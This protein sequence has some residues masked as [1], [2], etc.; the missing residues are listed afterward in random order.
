MPYASNRELP[1]QVKDNL[2]GHG[3]DI[4]REAFNHAF[5]N[6]KDPAKRRGHASREE[7][8]HKIAWSAVKHEYHKEGDHWVENRD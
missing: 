6:Y 1:T 3:Q 2:P 5:E 8:S 7:V 4:Y